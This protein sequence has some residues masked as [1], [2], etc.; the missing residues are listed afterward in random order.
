MTIAHVYRIT[1][2]YTMKVR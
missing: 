1:Q 2:S